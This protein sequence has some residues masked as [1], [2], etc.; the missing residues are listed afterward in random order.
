MNIRSFIFVLLVLSPFC[1]AQSQSNFQSGFLPSINLNKKFENDWSLNFKLESRQIVH[2]GDLR[3]D[4]PIRYDYELTDF[5]FITAKKIGID[6]TLAAGY[7]IRIRDQKPTH[8]FIQQYVITRSYSGFRLSHR[9]VADQT[10]DE[11]EPI[12]IRLR[13]RLST[14]FPLQGQT[15]DPK[16]LYIKVNHEYLNSFQDSNHDLEIRLI[17]FLGYV[18]NDD[19]KLE[20]GLDYR[21]N[22]FIKNQTSNR[23]WI[24]LNWFLSL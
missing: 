4:N 6:Q 1:Y 18:V 23:Y 10:F 7:M 17:P 15:V 16:E 13:Y 14:L 22:S 3:S 20:F 24:S 8:R 21:I 19:N 9:F 2:Q 11:N 12:E 5:T